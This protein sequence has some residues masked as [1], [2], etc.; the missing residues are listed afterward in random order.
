MRTGSNQ[1]VELKMSAIF[2]DLGIDYEI[3]LS[4]PA[5]FWKQV[6]AGAERLKTILK[7]DN[8]PDNYLKNKVASA[9]FDF[10]DYDKH[11]SNL[12]LEAEEVVPVGAIKELAKKFRRLASDLELMARDKAMLEVA[13]DQTMDKSVAHDMYKDLQKIAN[14]VVDMWNILHISHQAS[15]LPSMPGNYGG[16]Q[17]LVKYVFIFTGENQDGVPYR[18][19]T[20]VIRKLQKQGHIVPEMNNLMDLVD[21]LRANP[22]LG[23]T[24]S[25]Q[26]K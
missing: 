23:V 20:T 24:V 17:T 5:L 18:E 15:K 19:F 7:A 25:E 14:Q 12:L 1:K 10:S 9:D 4:E 6:E 3:M 22:E 21:Y 13:A 26:R 2:E 8:S 11:I 16:N